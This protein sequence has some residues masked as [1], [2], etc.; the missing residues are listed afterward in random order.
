MRFRGKTFGGLMNPLHGLAQDLSLLGRQ[1]FNSPERGLVG[2]DESLQS[3]LRD[4]M[5]GAMS[6]LGT[7]NC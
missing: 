2:L 3:L 1:R 4:S 5:I 7:L 6:R